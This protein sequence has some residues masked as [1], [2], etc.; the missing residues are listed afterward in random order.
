MESTRVLNFVLLYTTVHRGV[1]EK[2]SSLELLF[3]IGGYAPKAKSSTWSNFQGFETIRRSASAQSNVRQNVLAVPA[4]GK[5]VLH[6]SRVKVSIFLNC[7][8][9]KS[10]LISISVPWFSG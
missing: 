4:Q 5:G 8:F 3:S 2:I 9:H 10:E 1:F 6:A 7:I